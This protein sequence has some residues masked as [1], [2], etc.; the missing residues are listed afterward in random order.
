VALSWLGVDSEAIARLANNIEASNPTRG[1]ME[2]IAIM[3]PETRK[4]APKF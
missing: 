4:G 3:I 2:L 1:K